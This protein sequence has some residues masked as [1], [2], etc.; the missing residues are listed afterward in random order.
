MIFVTV[1]TSQYP[2]A[3]LI[4]WAI[5]AHQKVCPQEKLIIQY[6][7]VKI[8]RSGNK[9]IRMYPLVPF[10]K[11]ER[12]IA[13][14]RIVVTHCGI[15]N[16]LLCLKNGKKA[17]VAARVKKYGEHVSD[18]QKEG[19]EYLSQKKVIISVDT[20][21]ELEK[22]FSRAKTFNQ[23]FSGIPRTDFVIKTTQL[24]DQLFQGR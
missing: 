22:L 1:G 13:R 11:M 8:G 14:S 7:K 19:L 18:H 21:Q 20:Q 24:L 4:H 3:R 12:I 10:S 16:I 2:F 5:S 6:G 9:N 23:N 17:V 15:G